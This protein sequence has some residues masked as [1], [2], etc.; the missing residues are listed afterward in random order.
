M[1]TRHTRVGI[2]SETS[3]LY[4]TGYNVFFF[5]NKHKYSNLPSALRPATTWG[6]PSVPSP[7]V[8]KDLLPSSDEKI[9]PVEDPTKSVSFYDYVS[10]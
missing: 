2:D 5:R 10:V 3:V 8:N 4:M 9:S 1:R 7:E 6:I